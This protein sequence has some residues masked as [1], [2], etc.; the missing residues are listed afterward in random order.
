MLRIT[1]E[2]KPGRAVFRLEG[3]LTGE[4]VDELE[5]CWLSSKA[6]AGLMRSR[7]DLT[8]VS[9]VDE[10]GQALLERLVVQ[11]AELVAHSPLM[12]AVARTLTSRAKLH[13]GDEQSAVATTARRSRSD[14][15]P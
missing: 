1:I 5:R 3:K 2:E 9:F 11:G 7:I 6:R 8:G 10:K 15:H 4:W 13:K 12:I 14:L